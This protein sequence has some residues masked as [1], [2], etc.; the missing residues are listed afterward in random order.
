M[1]APINIEDDITQLI[2]AHREGDVQAYDQAIELL[3]SELRKLAHRSLVRAGGN[4]T[5]RTT[6]VVNEAYLKL[7]Q[8]PISAEDRAHF[9]GIAAKA[10]RQVIVDYARSRKAEKRGG[11]A[12]QV[13]L[14]DFNSAVDAQADQL[15]II[16]EALNQLARNN[17]RLATVFAYKFFVGL[18][19][20]ELAEA[21]GLSKRTAQREWKKARAFLAELVEEQRLPTVNTAD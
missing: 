20:D 15:L 19:D 13:P 16:D 11:D 10:M 21:T 12:I 4:P 18:E 7:R 3:Y 2:A 17:E 5:L 14:D 1:E 8:A 9:L 6:A